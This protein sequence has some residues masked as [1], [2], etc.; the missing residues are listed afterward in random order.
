MNSDISYNKYRDENSKS[1]FGKYFGGKK[2]VLRIT[3]IYFDN[4]EIRAEGKN[5]ITGDCD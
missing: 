3:F 4:Y 1:K 2:T 5:N